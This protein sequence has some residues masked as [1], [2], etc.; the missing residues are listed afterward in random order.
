MKKQKES[1]TAFTAAIF[2]IVENQIRESTPPE[3]K[4]TLER[5]IGAGHSSEQTHKLIA[6]VVST[7]IFDILTQGRPYNEERFVAALK[8]LPE[9]SWDK[10]E[11]SQ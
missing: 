6:A 8:R 5:L 2:E 7:E 11:D 1:L 9:M 4:Q 3:T 10:E